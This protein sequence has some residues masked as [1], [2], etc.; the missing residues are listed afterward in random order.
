MGL[1]CMVPP[2]PPIETLTSIFLCAIISKEQVRSA[3]WFQPSSILLPRTKYCIASPCGSGGG[4]CCDGVSASFRRV[5]LLLQQPMS[6]SSSLTARRESSSFFRYIKLTEVCLGHIHLPSTGREY[7]Q[8]V[9]HISDR[10]RDPSGPTPFADCR[11][12]S[13]GWGQQV[14]A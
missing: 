13:D 1:S 12:S 5:G 6:S 14:V 4:S 10:R 7:R 3:W 11:L 9:P 2:P 8:D